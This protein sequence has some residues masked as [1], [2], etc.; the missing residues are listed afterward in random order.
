MG[1]VK[2]SQQLDPGGAEAPTATTAFAVVPL[3]VLMAAQMGTSG[4]NGAL[5][6]AT[7]EITQAL[8]ASTSE[9]QMLNTVYSLVAG[10][11][12]IVGGM[13]GTMWGW[14]RNF[15]LGA[16][17]AAV[18]E[19]AAALAPNVFVLTWCGRLLVGLGASLLI[20]SVLGLVPKIWHTEQHRAQAYGGVASASGLAILFPII[21]GILLD[22]T[23]FRVTFAILG[24]YFLLVLAGSLKLPDVDRDRSSMRFDGVGAGLAASGLFLFI[25]GISNLSTWGMWT[26]TAAAPFSVGGLSPA[27][28]FIGGARH[29]ARQRRLPFAPRLP[30]RAAGALRPCRLHR[31]LLLHGH[32]DHSCHPLFAGGAWYVC[33]RNQRCLHCVWHRHV[34]CLG[35]HRAR[36][37]PAYAQGHHARGLCC[38]TCLHRP[39]GALHC[40]GR[41][42]DAAHGGRL[43]PRRPGRWCRSLA[44]RPRDL[45]CPR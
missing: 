3:I 5:S 22:L 19:F 30:C 37:S 21:L 20:P 31:E 23:G 1:L 43:C 41:F 4:D 27:P 39:V 11:C 45:A 38:G 17:L 36:L 6:I 44:G 12:M 24:V 42:G 32:A 7:G 15:R 18:G 14:R 25:N 40:A 35:G 26:A 10:A 13:L 29:R 28:L 9:I 2:A 33:P 16:G 34:H 8:G